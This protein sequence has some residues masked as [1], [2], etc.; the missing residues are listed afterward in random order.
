MSSTFTL[1]LTPMRKR[2]ISLEHAALHDTFIK[3]ETSPDTSHTPGP[4]DVPELDWVETPEQGESFPCTP[5]P[6]NTLRKVLP[7]DAKLHKLHVGDSGETSSSKLLKALKSTKVKRI[8]SVESHLPGPR[9]IELAKGIL[10]PLHLSTPSPAQETEDTRLYRFM[11]DISPENLRFLS[12]FDSPPNFS[13]PNDQSLAAL[14]FAIQ[15]P[16]H[17]V[18]SPLQKRVRVGNERPRESIDLQTKASNTDLSSGAAP[19]E[20]R[21]ITVRP[22]L[23]RQAPIKAQVISHSRA[24]GHSRTNPKLTGSTNRRFTRILDLDSIERLIENHMICIASLAKS[25][26]VRCSMQIVSTDEAKDQILN[27]ISELKDPLDLTVCESYIRGLIDSFTCQ[28]YHHRIATEQ[29]GAL[30][31]RYHDRRARKPNKVNDFTQ[32]NL[33]SLPIWL[34]ALTRLPGEQTIQGVHIASQTY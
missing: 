15:N 17:Y 13:K 4:Q 18:R 22:P 10:F 8:S 21:N 16:K 31:D 26:S 32:D 7:I 25:P 1:P 29:L 3:Q 24:S 2:A 19:F 34:A 5:S 28:R 23:L 27:Q 9:D 14:R 20:K 30:F 33:A 11:G 12:P 6:I